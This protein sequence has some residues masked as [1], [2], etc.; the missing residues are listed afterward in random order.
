MDEWVINVRSVH[1]MEY[2]SAFKR[3]EIRTRAITWI[4]LEDTMLS[5]HKGHKRT[6]TV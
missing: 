5:E 2:Y 4:S 3:K 1:A 6:K